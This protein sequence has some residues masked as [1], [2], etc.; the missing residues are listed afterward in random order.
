M[1]SSGRLT[2][3]FI[4]TGYS[5][6][7]SLAILSA[8]DLT[9]SKVLTKAI[10]KTTVYTY[11]SLRIGDS[12]FV[13]LVNGTVTLFR[14]VKQNDYVVR[15][16]NCY[17]SIIAGVWR[18]YSRP[19]IKKYIIRNRFPTKLYYTKYV[20]PSLVYFRKN[21]GPLGK[22]NSYRKRATSRRQIARKRISN[23][24]QLIVSRP[25]YVRSKLVNTYYKYYYYTQ[26][27]GYQIF[28]NPTM[29]NYQRCLYVNGIPTCEKVLTLPKTFT[30]KNHK[31]Y[32]NINFEECSGI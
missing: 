10:N 5:I 2:Y 9:K 17:Y 25:T 28:Y 26:P 18:C 31:V 19:A 22:L 3:Q 11:G 32:Y 29:T 24:K 23:R 27:L 1:K 7:G 15:V 6:G 14:V 8:F 12:K 16:P 13:A 4:F 30:T 20:Y 21:R